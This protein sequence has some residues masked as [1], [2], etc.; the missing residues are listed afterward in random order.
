MASFP[1]DKQ[2]DEDS[3]ID[4]IRERARARFP[5]DKL[6]EAL[7]KYLYRTQ[8]T[9]YFSTTPEGNRCIWGNGKSFMLRYHTSIL[10]LH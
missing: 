5:V 10:T 2:E 3:T 9:K 6:P 4:W 1:V 8:S 7:Q